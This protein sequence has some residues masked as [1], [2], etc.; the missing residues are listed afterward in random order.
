VIPALAVRRPSK[1]PVVPTFRALAAEMPPEVRIA[2][3]IEEVASSVDGKNVDALAPVP[4][5]V[6]SAVAPARAVKDVLDVVI[7]VVISGEVIA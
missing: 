5:R 1:V 6:R 4:P 3:V 2:P 7:D